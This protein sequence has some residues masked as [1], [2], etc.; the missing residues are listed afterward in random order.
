MRESP[1]TPEEWV[2][3]LDELI[4]RYSAWC[5]DRDLHACERTKEIV[6]ERARVLE[7]G[8]IDFDYIY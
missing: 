6:A 1:D 7:T 8:S 3:H 2:E 4:A 5:R